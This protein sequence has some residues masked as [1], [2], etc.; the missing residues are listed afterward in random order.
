LGLRFDPMGGGQ[1]KQAV[2]SIIEAEG[3]PIRQLEGHKAKEQQRLKLFQEFKAK[4]AGMDKAIADLNNFQSFRELKVDMGEGQT[5]ASVTLDKSKAQPGTYKIQ[6]DDLASRSSVI[7]NGFPDPNEKSLG[8][9]YVV[10]NQKNGDSKEILIEDDKSS[11]NGMASAINSSG[12]PVTASV[13]KD[14]SDPENPWRMIMAAKKDGDQNQVEIPEL[15]FMDGDRDISFD[16]KKEAHNA[17][18]QVND[19]SIEAE[20]NDV[21]DFLP[22]IN[23]HMKQAKP[24]T[25]FTLT[26]SEDSQ[27][28][29]GKVKGL[30]DQ[31]NEILGFI[32]KQNSIDA[33]TDTSTTFAGDTSLQNVEYRLRNLMQEAFPSGSEAKGNFRWIHL[34]ELGVEFD[35]TGKLTFKDDKFQKALENDFDAIAEG[36]SGE[37]GLASQLRQTISSYTQ[38]GT[39]LISIR[40]KGMRDRIAD[41][42]RQIDEKSKRLDQRQQQLTDQYARLEGSLADMQRQS[43]ALGSLGGG[44]GSGL[45]SLLGG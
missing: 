30:V 34:N 4:F 5:L 26:V 28:V 3:Q 38:S 27:K 18:I 25:P 13:I 2:K 35:K 7:T 43:A 29:T 14:L 37:H 41:M 9:G 45:M 21:K 6:I 39:G 15:Y 24:D 44:G 31:M 8:L 20:S 17:R 11:L 40:E 32:G 1:F 33:G 23:L 42:D 36:I 16:D 22:G 12:A 10:F 19:F